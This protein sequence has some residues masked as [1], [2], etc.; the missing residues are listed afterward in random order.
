MT[1]AEYDKFM[2]QLA[3]C[4]PK[5]DNARIVFA[6][7]IGEEAGEVV[8]KV[9][10]FYRGDPDFDQKEVLKELGDLLGYISCLAQDLGSNLDEVV[11]M[12]TAKMTKRIEAGTLLG[13]GDNR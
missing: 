4:Y 5:T 8:G 9:K 7:G 10:R 13:K 1:F 11:A 6:L 12:H 3:S 2:L